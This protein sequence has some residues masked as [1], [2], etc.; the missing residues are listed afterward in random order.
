MKVP[1]KS[2][3]FFVLLKEV[4]YVSLFVFFVTHQCLGDASYT[5]SVSIKLIDSVGNKM[6]VDTVIKSKYDYAYID[7][8]FFQKKNKTLKLSK[9]GQ[10]TLYDM[11]IDANV[12]SGC[13]C[14]NEPLLLTAIGKVGALEVSP[15]N[16]VWDYLIPTSTPPYKKLPISSAAMTAAQA[17]DPYVQA[18]IPDV[19]MLRDLVLNQVSKNAGQ[20]LV[21]PTGPFTQSTADPKML[22][23][24]SQ[25]LLN[26]VK[27]GGY[28][29]GQEFYTNLIV[30]AGENLLKV[31]SI[32]QGLNI[33]PSDDALTKAFEDAIKTGQDAPDAYSVPIAIEGYIPKSGGGTVLAE[34]STPYSR[35]IYTRPPK[36]I[37]EVDCNDCFKGIKPE[38]TAK[39]TIYAANNSWVE[40]KPN[41]IPDEDPRVH[42]SWYGLPS[43]R[44]FGLGR[45]FSNVQNQKLPGK[46][47]LTNSLMQSGMYGLI[48][49]RGPIPPIGCGAVSNWTE[50]FV[51]CSDQPGDR[52]GLIK[53]EGDNDFAEYHWYDLSG[54]SKRVENYEPV[55]PEG[56]DITLV[57]GGTYSNHFCEYTYEW[58]GPGLVL[59]EGSTNEYI[60][61]PNVLIGGVSEVD[62]IESG[63]PTKRMVP[64]ETS[65]TLTLK[66]MKPEMSGIYTRI[67][68]RT[69]N[70]AGLNPFGWGCNNC[71]Q[72]AQLKINVP[73]L[74]PELTSN[75]PACEGEDITIVLSSAPYATHYQWAYKKNIADPEPTQWSS[76]IE[77]TSP[78]ISLGKATLAMSGFYLI[79]TKNVITYPGFGEASG[80]RKTVVSESPTPAIIQIE[81]K[82]E[83][84]I[85]L[86]FSKNSVYAG[87]QAILTASLPATAT[88]PAEGFTLAIS[89][90][91]SSAIKSIDYE[92]LPPTIYIPPTKNA[93]SV[94]LAT[95]WTNSAETDEQKKIMIKGE[96]INTADNNFCYLA[97]IQA[98]LTIMAKHQLYVSFDHQI[99]EQGE[100]ALL[101]ISLSPTTVAPEGGLLIHLNQEGSSAESGIHYDE[102]PSTIL[103]PEG[104][105]SIAI[106]IT[107]K[108]DIA[109]D[110]DKLLLINPQVEGYWVD[111][112]AALSI[113]RNSSNNA[114]SIAFTELSIQGGKTAMLTAQLPP[115]INASHLINITLQ[116]DPSSGAVENQ[117]Y[118]NLKANITIPA[119]KNEGTIDAFKAKNNNVIDDSST[120]ILQAEAKSSGYTIRKPNPSIIIVDQTGEDSDNRVLT[121]DYEQPTI[122]GGKIARLTIGLP[123]GITSAKPILI[124]L[125]KKQ[126][127]P[128]E[129]QAKV[130]VDYKEFSWDVVLKARTNSTNIPISTMANNKA[131]IKT[132]WLTGKAPGYSF[133]SKKLTI[134]NPQIVVPNA[135]T[136]EADI[137]NRWEIPN[138]Y[139][140]EF[141]QVKVINK[142]GNI[143]FESI[144]YPQYGGWDGTY[145]NQP[146]PQGAYYYTIDLKDGS[147]VLSGEVSIII[148]S[149]LNRRPR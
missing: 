147:P 70:G 105:N 77:L 62:V 38:T 138:L 63:I 110:R 56:S 113:T 134:L 115:G 131:K 45:G 33:L 148:S 1:K 17:I 68:M 65:E 95:K 71:F 92:P 48:K 53:L 34:T 36:A 46:I 83:V 119:G 118:V 16:V 82:K 8:S 47:T 58:Y 72:I 140:Y 122:R 91:G 41:D 94:T 112:P 141:C 93:V 125:E 101:T 111:N 32:L 9:L 97:P 13:L 2:N 29:T 44:A 89:D 57:S 123:P 21:L 121:L 11:I 130:N 61:T 149:E 120:L 102:I 114:I 129:Q 22:Q 74:I 60:M 50:L 23:S 66:N 31:K 12:S 84:P 39:T 90:E 54:K 55:L 59:K 107:T 106:P 5:S 20:F 67:A 51:G 40:F 98:A 49:Y 116:R 124:R 146:L 109:F 43:L 76:W 3:T 18:M 24:F 143:V 144:G 30:N 75:S 27:L 19:P 133:N 64:V 128:V 7:P 4:L 96:L 126:V 100:K 81:V 14:A 10:P 87:E 137:H 73:Q 6:K 25:S 99:I 42:Y 145:Y 28:M 78:K 85:Q 142:W 132:L 80:S 69:G 139:L 26:L 127:V 103:L 37:V 117:D 108:G 135:F 136:P 86:S 15:Q 104:Q 88:I 35:P 79:K 52:E